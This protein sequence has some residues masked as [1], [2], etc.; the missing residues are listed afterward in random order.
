LTRFGSETRC[1]LL[2]VI[3][4]DAFLEPARARG[5]G[6]YAGVPCSFLTPEP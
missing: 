1:I 3:D 2:H 4:A 5:F 6:F